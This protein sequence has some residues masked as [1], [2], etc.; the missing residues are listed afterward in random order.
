MMR[1]AKG[2][3]PNMISFHN[4]GYSSARSYTVV[5]TILINVQSV[6]AT[7]QYAGMLIISFVTQMKV[8]GLNQKVNVFSVPSGLR[9]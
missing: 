8:P 9:I 7:H 3:V 6:A 2:S 1:T 4:K 5:P